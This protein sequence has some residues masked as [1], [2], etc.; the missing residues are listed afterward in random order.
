MIVVYI[1]MVVVSAA[2][3]R[4]RWHRVS[5]VLRWR[6]LKSRLPV[7]NQIPHAE[8]GYWAT[9]ERRKRFVGKH[10]ADLPKIRDWRWIN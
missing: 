2:L 1:L 8:V 5:V 7:F 6:M 10:G 9:M 3:G 4:W